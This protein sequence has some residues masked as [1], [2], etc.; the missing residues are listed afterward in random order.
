MA[1]SGSQLT[2]IGAFLSGIAKKLTI[3]PKAEK[4]ILLGPGA[5]YSTTMS[6]DGL[7]LGTNLSNNGIGQIGLMSNDGIGVSTLM[8][9]SGIGES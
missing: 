2:R 7:G 5:G 9:N 6:N 4:I 1:A 3:T 8:G